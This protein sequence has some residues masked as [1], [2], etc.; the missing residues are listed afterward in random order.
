MSR[1]LTNP[2]QRIVSNAAKTLPRNTGQVATQQR[3]LERR[4][5]GR[6]VLADVSFSMSTR[7]DDGRRKIDVLREAVDA[8]L[9][10]VVARLFVFSADVREAQMIPEPE[11]GT[12]LA[13]A[14]QAVRALDPGVTLLISDGLPDDPA[15]ALLEAEKFRGVIDVM[16]IG[17]ASDRK[18]QAFLRDLARKAGGNLH[19]VDLKIAARLPLSP[20]IAGL[21]K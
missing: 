18:A 11:A 8:A 13:Q 16:Y 21:L 2:L 7:V 5:G 14:L 6:M 15:A 10:Q 1:A 3:A 12:N 19:S 9:R 17:P 4:S 20:R